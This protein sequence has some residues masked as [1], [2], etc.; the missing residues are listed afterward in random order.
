[1]I[2]RG[3][4]ASVVY[5]LSPNL[6]EPRGPGGLIESSPRPADPVDAVQL[7]VIAL[8]DELLARLEYERARDRAD[9]ERRIRSG[10]YGV[11]EE[12]GDR[13]P[14]RRLMAVP[15]SRYCRPCQERKERQGR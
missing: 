8:Q 6:P 5:G 9:A 3:G 14:K 2:R 11:C 10:H 4:G 13:I 12:C 1:M 15:F 7:E